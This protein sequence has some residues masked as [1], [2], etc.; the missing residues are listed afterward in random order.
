MV[1]KREVAIL[2]LLVLVSIT[3]IGWFWAEL[4]PARGRIP[5][6]NTYKWTEIFG[7]YEAYLDQRI[8]S[9]EVKGPSMVPTFGDGDVVLWVE[10]DNM[11]ELE[12]G[13]I[14]IFNHPTRPIGNI[15]HRI[16]EVG[17]NGEYRFKTNGD[18]LP[19]SDS[20]WV[21]EGDVHGLV[22]GVIYRTAPG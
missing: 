2:A 10:I 21:W 11:A 13:D 9:S 12:A 5:Y 14:I 18:A 17:M 20:Y 7:G 3:A 8:S 4:N 19:E 16:L 1:D 22:I 6:D 15:A